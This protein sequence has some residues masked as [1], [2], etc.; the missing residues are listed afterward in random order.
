MLISL[1][2][3][4]R[5]PKELAGIHLG[6]QKRHARSGR[7]RMG[8]RFIGGTPHMHRCSQPRV[9]IDL[10]I[11]MGLDPRSLCCIKRT[12]QVILLPQ[13]HVARR[14]F[15]QLQNSDNDVSCSILCN[16]GVN[17]FCVNFQ[18]FRS[19]IMLELK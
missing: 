5:E 13:V 7:S 8:R 3:K 18:Y 11:A 16:F 6:R 9:C 15:S 14:S 10:V 17:T 12:Q 4:H 2:C 1:I 19:E